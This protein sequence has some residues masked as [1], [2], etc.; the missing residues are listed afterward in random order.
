MDEYTME[1]Y[2]VFKKKEILLFVTTWI[3]LEHVTVRKIGQKEK[4]QI[5]HNIIY[6]WKLKKRKKERSGT[7]GRRGAVV[8]ARD[9]GAEE[10][11][12]G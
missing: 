4:R 6:M 3:K 11:G 10:A 5:L 8:V 9:L 7:H 1:C 2:S 12:G